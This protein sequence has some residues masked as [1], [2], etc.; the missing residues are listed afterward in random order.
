[1]GA[2][3]KGAPNA[4]RRAEPSSVEMAPIRWNTQGFQRGRAREPLRLLAAFRGAGMLSWSGGVAGVA[5]E[6][7]I[8]GSGDGR[9]ASGVIEGEIS[10]LPASSGAGDGQDA[11][12]LP[13]R[14]RLED[15][16][17]IAIEITGFES[18]L[19]YFEARLVAAD[20]KLLP[21]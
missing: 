15:G 11:P 2:I 7:D 5:Y 3:S 19:A 17:E 13:A 14:L 9:S 12:L 1:M 21:E 16:H 18:P 8:F 20:A 4:K 6:L 10:A